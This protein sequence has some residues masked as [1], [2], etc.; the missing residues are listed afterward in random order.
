MIILEMPVKIKNQGMT[1]PEYS[2]KFVPHKFAAL[3]ELV[4]QMLSFKPEDRP[5]I[6]EVED[7]IKE[8]RIN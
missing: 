7:I 8:F 4:K 2:K 6:Q 5:S 3:Y 1:E